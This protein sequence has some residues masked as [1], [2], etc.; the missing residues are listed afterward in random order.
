MKKTVNRLIKS[1]IKCEHCAKFVQATTSETSYC[2][3]TL[4]SK[5]YWNKC[6]EFQWKNDKTPQSQGR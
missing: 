6:K 4:F 5:N 1:N 3:L 2:K